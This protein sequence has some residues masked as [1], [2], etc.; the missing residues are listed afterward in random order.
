MCCQWECHGCTGMGVLE[1]G[2]RSR[3]DL[4]EERDVNRCRALAHQG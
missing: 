1:Q 3:K 4:M 2:L